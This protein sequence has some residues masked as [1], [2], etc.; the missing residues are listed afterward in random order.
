MLILSDVQKSKNALIAKMTDLGIQNNDL[1]QA[2][3][4]ITEKFELIELNAERCDINDQIEDHGYVL[5]K[6]VSDEN[7]LLIAAKYKNNEL[8][9]RTSGDEDFRHDVG[10]AF[11]NTVLSKQI[12]SAM[13]EVEYLESNKVTL[14]ALAIVELFQDEID[15]AIDSIRVQHGISYAG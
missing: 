14:D 4:A 7:D 6:L 1:I 11:G 10:I 8:M 3:R 15:I 13:Y 5:D 2:Q 9:Y 12:L